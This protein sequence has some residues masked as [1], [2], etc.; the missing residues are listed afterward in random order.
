MELTLVDLVDDGLSSLPVDV[1]D[2]DVSAETR[3]LQRVCAPESGAG[4]GDDYRL[5]VK[6]DFLRGLR[7]LSDLR[8][9]RDLCLPGCQDRLTR[10]GPTE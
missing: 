2:D 5:A 10:R 4:T 3:V 7:V 6:P 9:L 8:G 1:I